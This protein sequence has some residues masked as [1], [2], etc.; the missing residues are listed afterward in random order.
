MLCVLAEPMC[1]DLSGLTRNVLTFAAGTPSDVT[2]GREN[3]DSEDTHSAEC[4]NGKQYETLP[5]YGV[6]FTCQ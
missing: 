6:I 3:T 2:L 4:D 1:T 5:T